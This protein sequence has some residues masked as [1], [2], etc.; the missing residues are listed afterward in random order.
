MYAWIC[1]SSTQGGGGGGARRGCT[2][3]RDFCK[4]W[5][6]KVCPP[7]IL[8]YIRI[9]QIFDLPFH[10]PPKKTHSMITTAVRSILIAI[11]TCHVF[12]ASHVILHS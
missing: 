1:F 4:C 7:G 8:S 2:N 10:V 9:P 5:L 11:K 6:W 12:L 3:R